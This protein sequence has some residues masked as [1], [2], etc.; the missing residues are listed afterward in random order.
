MS[1]NGSEKLF[2]SFTDVRDDFVYEVQESIMTKKTVT[3]KRN[4]KYIPLAACFIFILLSV[5]V[6][7]STNWGIY[8][9]EKFTSRTE[10]GSDYTESG[11]D[12]SVSVEKKSVQSLKGDVQK[13]PELIIKQFETT[14]IFSSWFPG[15]WQEMFVSSEDAVDFIGLAELRTLNWELNEEQVIL[16]VFGNE[17]GEILSVRLETAYIVNDI[18]I[19]AITSI[20]TEY[21]IEP[22]EIGIRTTESVEF[23]EIFYET[24]NS[25]KCYIISGTAL[26]SGYLGMDGYLVQEGV[27]Y[28]VHIAYQEFDKSEAEGLLYL[29]ADSF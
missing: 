19:Q 23:D 29:W 5:T 10:I 13:V 27:L 8:L 7:A 15:H 28:N 3:G 6:L 12:I 1:C 14:D 2:K 4:R 17:N 11:Y 20:F 25:V 26:E 9:I 24:P 22:V 18:R 21:D 16:D